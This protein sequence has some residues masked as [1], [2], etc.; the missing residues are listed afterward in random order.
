MSCRSNLR[1]WHA[2]AQNPQHVHERLIRVLRRR[3]ADIGKIRN[4]HVYFRETDLN[5]GGTANLWLLMDENPYSINDG[6]FECNPDKDGWVDFPASYHDGAGGL[7][8]CDGHAQYHKWRDPLVLNDHTENPS[9]GASVAPTIGY[10]DFTFLSGAST[11]T[12][13]ADY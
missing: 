8:F 1:R 9:T 5:Y 10:N 11:V 13:V 4:C 3:Q 7:S 2:K 12:N 6:F